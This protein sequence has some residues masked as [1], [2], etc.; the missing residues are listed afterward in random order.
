[1]ESDNLAWLCV[2]LGLPAVMESELGAVGNR[3]AIA[4]GC[5]GQ[6]AS[7]EAGL[8]KLLHVTDLGDTLRDAVARARAG[9]AV[10]CVIGSGPELAQSQLRVIATPHGPGCAHV[11]VAP[12]SLAAGLELS[13]RAGLVD[14]AAAVAHE[15]ANAVGAIA[16]WAELGA[17]AAAGISQDEALKLIGSCARAAQQ[18]ARSMLSASR[19]EAAEQ[20]QE[21]DLSALAGELLSLLSVTARQERV[22]LTSNLEPD[23]KVF[24]ARSQLFTVL[25]NLSKNAI[26]ACAPNGVVS[27][28]LGASGSK[29]VLEVRDNGLGLHGDE[30]ARIFTPYYTTKASG[31]GLGLALVQQAVNKLGGEIT[32]QSAKGRG[33]S[34]RVALP[35]LARH[36]S[37]VVAALKE[38]PQP[39]SNADLSARILVVDDDDALR[40]MLATALSL[41]GADVV[42]AKS[43]EQACRLEG[44]FDIALIDMMLEDCRG[45]ELLTTLRRR[46][47]VSAAILVTGTVQKPRLTP[48]GE[49][50]DWVRKPFEIG[51]LV[52]RIQ[53]TLDR[54][55]MLSSL[56]GTRRR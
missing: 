20:E 44:R 30:L 2:E 10:S 40:G 13:R 43:S 9:E 1:M 53:H 19:G 54:H 21:V 4:A 26:E 41:R 24:G 22:R 50:D 48:G 56:T 46:D 11:I 45:D 3:A 7:L 52:E 35:R 37:K 14:V 51:M 23:L 16:G 15:V 39:A 18:A 29:L 5:E 38:V 6:L 12:A 42:T 28:V 34:F 25:W 27:V 47:T 17:G 33:T 55:R 8:E 31:T 49:P 36:H 32:V